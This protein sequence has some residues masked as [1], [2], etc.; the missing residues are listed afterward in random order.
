MP[1]DSS[2]AVV[3]L[4]EDEIAVQNLVRSALEADGFFLLTACD[5]V[6]ALEV[7]RS[8]SG[9]IH[10]LL[11]DVTMPR[12]DGLELCRRIRE[13]RQSTRVILMSGNPPL[14]RLDVP[15]LQKPFGIQCLRDTVRRVIEPLFRRLSNL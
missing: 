7:S 4:A 8:Y 1:S 14:E 2:Q 10:L 6:D 11:S 15:L 13:E 12:L 3:L 5:G 9:E